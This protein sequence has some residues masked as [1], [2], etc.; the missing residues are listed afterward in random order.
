[1]SQAFDVNN[2]CNLR[3]TYSC[4]GQ[5]LVMCD[6]AISFCHVTDMRYVINPVVWNIV[7]YISVSEISE[8]ACP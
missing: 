8:V 2:A 7:L 1:V 3:M 4:K 6:N 5:Y